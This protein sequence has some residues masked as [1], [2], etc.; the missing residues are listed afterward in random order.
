[1]P[2][3][4]RKHTRS[5]RDS[6]RSQNWKLDALSSSSCPN[7]ECKRLRPPHTVCPHCGWYDGRIVLAPKVKKKAAEGGEQKGES[8]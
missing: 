3:P 6:R 4:K 8:Q 2:N 1:M 7:P 5:R